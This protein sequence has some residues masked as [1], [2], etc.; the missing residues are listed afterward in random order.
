MNAHT[1]NSSPILANTHGN[2]W[3]R[4]YKKLVNIHD[5]P[6][7]IALGFGLGVFTGILPGTGLVASLVLAF[8]FRV[9]RVAA[10]TGSLLTNTWLSFVTFLFSIKVGSW[11]TGAQWSQVH[12]ELKDVLRDFHWKNLFDRNLFDISMMQILYPL[13]IGYLLVGLL[14]GLI[15]YFLVLVVLTSHARKNTVNP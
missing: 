13:I 14:L 9:N 5:T 11:V 3:Q 2:F 7:K 4:L 6:Q 1:S 12:Q 10:F 8:V 15:T